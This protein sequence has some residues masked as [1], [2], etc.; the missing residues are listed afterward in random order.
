MQKFRADA[1]VES[2]AA[3]DV[4]HVGANFLGQVGNLIDEGD[5][6]GE[7]GVRRVFD[8]LGGA[9][10]GVE[11]GRLVEVKRPINLGHELARALV[12]GA[13]HDAIGMLEVL[14]GGAFAQEFRI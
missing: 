3:R 8:K 9:A 12:V 10:A 1:I 2:D 14:D 13:D 11:D 7:E 6:G 4:L 5:L